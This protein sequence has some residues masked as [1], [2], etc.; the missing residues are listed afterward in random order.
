MRETLLAAIA[1]A[2]E[3]KAWHGTNLRGALRGVTEEQA[4]WRPA[5]ERHNIW[6]L[7]LHCAYWKYAVRRRLLGEKPGAFPRKGSNFPQ[8]TNWSDDRE[9]LVEMHR[10]LVTTIESLPAKKIE[11]S[12]RMIYGIA[13][14]DTYHTGQIQL[15]KRFSSAQ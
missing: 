1:D 14:H 13:L 7:A 9:L 11:S 8:P 15:L 10:A 2:L 6:E 3:K 5:N 4:S 12:Q